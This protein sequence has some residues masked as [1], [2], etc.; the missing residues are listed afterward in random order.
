MP[1]KVGFEVSKADASLSLS[2]SL[3][4][5]DVVLSHL[6]STALACCHA[7][8]LDDNGLSCKQVP[9][10]MFSFIRVVLVMVSLSSHNRTVNK[11]KSVAHLFKL[12]HLFS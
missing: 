7:V 11:A 12:G 6:F 10:K 3:V 9:S 4:D 8:C 1:L 2:F 5:W